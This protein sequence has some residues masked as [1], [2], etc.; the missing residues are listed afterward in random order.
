MDLLK[1]QKK[2][3]K[4]H[5]NFQ[6]FLNQV[7]ENDRETF[8]SW[9]E[10]FPDRD[11][12][13]VGEFQR[14]FNSSF[15]EVYLFKLFTDLGFNFTDWKEHPDFILEKDNIH[16]TIEATISNNGESDIAEWDFNLVEEWKNR[17]L[18]KLQ[19]ELLQSIK[20]KNIYSIIRFESSIRSKREK[21]L[22]KY[23]NKLWVEK[24]PFVIALGSYEQPLHYIQYDRAIMA[25]LYNY[26][27]DEE[28]FI[29]NP[30]NY[31]DGQPPVIELNSVI[32][33][34]GSELEL[35][36]FLDDRVSEI[37]A[38]L[39]NPLAIWKKVQNMSYDKQGVFKHNWK[40]KTG[41]ILV[42]DNEQELI[43]DGL[44]IFHNPYA[45]YP[46][47]KDIFN[48]DRI[49]QVFMD[50]ETGNLTQEFGEKHLFNHQTIG[51]IIKDNI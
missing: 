14:T 39:F 48:K 40:D 24:K 31:P 4:F 25:L 11:K 10:N 36:I 1:N 51:F 20:P 32:R 8:L 30:H 37:S 17:D 6:D 9:A 46:L 5:K 3:K 18:D 49:C 43:K 35:G 50:K 44:F 38:I 16:F 2:I 7:P 12:K 26:Y 41:N 28:K 23:Q 21:Y 13:F 27:V 45:K 33:P 15:W 19:K 29:K 34:N 47:P 42:T 22:S